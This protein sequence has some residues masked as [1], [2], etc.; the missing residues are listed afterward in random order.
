[1]KSVFIPIVIFVVYILVMYIRAI[2]IV[3]RMPKEEEQHM[4]EVAKRYKR[5]K[6]LKKQAK[7]RGGSLHFL[8]Y[9]SPLNNWGLWK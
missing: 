7:H 4:L 5:I 8:S 1:M 9:P 2:Y 3:A 6:N